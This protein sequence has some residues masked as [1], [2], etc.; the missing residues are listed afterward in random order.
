MVQL[1]RDKGRFAAGYHG[2]LKLAKQPFDELIVQDA[3]RFVEAL[4]QSRWV[5]PGR[6]DDSLLVTRLLAFGGPMFRVFSEPE[7]AVIRDWIRGLDQPAIAGRST[8]TACASRRPCRWPRRRYRL[9]R[10]Y[11]YERCITAC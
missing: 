11:R 9:T 8:A 6:P 1:V 2:K 3:E 7:E 5:S 10:A 4:G